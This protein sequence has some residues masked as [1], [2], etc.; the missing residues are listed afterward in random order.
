MNPNLTA[1]LRADRELRVQVQQQQLA[2]IQEQLEEALPELQSAYDLAEK[3]GIKESNYEL[4]Q[5]LGDALTACTE[6]LERINDA[7]DA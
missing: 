2:E 1:N 4:L 6:A 7:P 3:A 5:A